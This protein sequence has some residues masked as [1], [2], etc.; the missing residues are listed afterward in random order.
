MPS[1]LKLLLVVRYY[2]MLDKSMTLHALS[3]KVNAALP[4]K[5]A[6]TLVAACALITCI[7]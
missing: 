6:Y 3:D 2:A 4:G 7:N 5:M 1:A